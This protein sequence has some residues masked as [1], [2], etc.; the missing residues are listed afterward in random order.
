M[1]LRVWAWC[2]NCREFHIHA[3]TPFLRAAMNTRVRLKLAGRAS[4][5]ERVPLTQTWTT[6][7]QRELEERGLISRN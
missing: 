5:I 2:R 3:E 1:K 7:D 6:P 4:A